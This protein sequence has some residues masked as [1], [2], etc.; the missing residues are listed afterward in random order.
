MA[1]LLLAYLANGARTPYVKPAEK[2]A[3]FLQGTDLEATER[4]KAWLAGQNLSLPDVMSTPFR[5][6]AVQREFLHRYYTEMAR[7]A[8]PSN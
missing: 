4:I 7:N 8:F 6:Q 5:Q 1:P 2:C 3:I